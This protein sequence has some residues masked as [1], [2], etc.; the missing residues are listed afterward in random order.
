VFFYATVEM[1][2]CPLSISVIGDYLLFLI[3]SDIPAISL[4][5]VMLCPVIF[6]WYSVGLSCE[7][8]DEKSKIHL[9]GKWI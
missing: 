8:Y 2:V 4:F 9:D 6:G 1:V 3:I 7:L 5:P